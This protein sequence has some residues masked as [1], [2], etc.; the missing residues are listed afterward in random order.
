MYN[1]QLET[2]LC[3]AECGSFNKAAEKLFISPPAVIKQINL[4][5]ENLDLQL[6]VRT[7]RGLQLTEAG[8]SL[9]QDAKYI[10]QYCKDS[11]TRAK[12]VMKKSED[13][14]RIGTSSMT[15]AQVLVDLW[16]KL[17][18]DQA[19]LYGT[20]TMLGGY[21]E[22]KVGQLPTVMSTPPRADWVNPTGKAMGNFIVAVDPQGQLAYSGLSI[23]KKGRPAAHVI[24][25][26]TEQVAPEY[27][28]YL[29]NQGV[30]YLF[31]GEKRLNCTLLLEKLHRLFGIN[32]LMLA[33]GGIVNGSFLAE[34]L[35][36]ELSLVI[37]PVADGGNG[38]SSF[39]QVDFLPS[40]PPTAFHLKEVQT[41]VPNVLW[42]RYTRP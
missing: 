11:V 14:I 4:L 29:Q 5:E 38:V 2:F 31:A 9:V 24:E 30:S 32:K 6:F 17:Q 36:D 7:H 20:T 21:A 42:V 37:A 34:N 33:G 16:P 25:A 10:I 1:P 13:I 27:L 12:N 35:V 8:K 26:L 3:V 19:T 22:G 15:P 28:S 41:V 18:E 40:W 39:T 23:E